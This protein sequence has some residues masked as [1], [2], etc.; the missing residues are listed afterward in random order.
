ML[1]AYSLPETLEAGGQTL[2]V[3]SRGDWRVVIDAM[4]ALGDP[5][6][7]ESERAYAAL[8]IFYAEDPGTFKDPEAAF[9]A[10]SEFMDAGSQEAENAPKRPKLIDWETDGALVVSGVNKV[11]G[12]EIR[13]LPY[14][15]WWT[16]M[17]AYMGIGEGALST[18]VGIRD[19]LARGRKLDKTEKDFRRD[20]PQ[21][22]QMDRKALKAGRDMLLELWG[23]EPSE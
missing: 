7:K 15:H 10:M 6:L 11:L 16:F 13:A 1:S 19:K 23:E 4:I 9:R 18:V 2:A 14:M 20:N 21:Y 12:Q 3:R 5:E 22:F 8:N 17:A